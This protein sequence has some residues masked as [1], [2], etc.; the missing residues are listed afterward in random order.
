MTL[1]Q[2]RGHD[3]GLARLDGGCIAEPV[4]PALARR[5][6]CDA[7]IIPA[8][9]GGASEVLDLGRERRL[10]SPAQR[11]ALALRDNGCAFP[12]CDRPPP[13][14]DAHLKSWAQGGPT[15]VDNLVLLCGPHHDLVHHAGWTIT[16]GT[17]RRPR[18][19]PPTRR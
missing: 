3:A 11:R 17:D 10:A 14:T 2:L 13:W 19:R 16:L 4:T 7:G 12:A 9:L 18:F 15:D 8:V 5:I 6:A 1:D